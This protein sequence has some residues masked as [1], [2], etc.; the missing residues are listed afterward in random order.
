VIT[1]RSP[2]CGQ[3]VIV[4]ESTAGRIGRITDRARRTARKNSG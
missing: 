2:R 3:D 4:G 1:L